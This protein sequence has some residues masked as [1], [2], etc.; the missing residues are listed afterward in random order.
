MAEAKPAVQSASG[1]S[2]L[3][4]AELV[5]ALSLAVDLGLGQPM[6]HLARSCLVACRLGQRMGLDDEERAGLY[7]VAML[8]WVG[9]IADS[10][11]AA[12]WFG[13][14]ISYRAEVYDIDMKPLPF[15]GY[16][17][18]RAGSGQ[19]PT[20]RVLVGANLV[21]TGA[22][23][24]QDSLRAHCQ[25]TGRIAERLGLGPDV[26]DPLQQIF[27]RW[28]AKGLPAGLGGERVAIAVRMW[29]IADVAEV[30]HR[31]GGVEAAVE[32]ARRRSGSQFDPAV[33]DE[34]IACAGEILDALPEGSCWD[35]LI[36][37]EPA[38]RPVLSER[39]F[40]AVLE[41]FAD[42]AD[43][44]SPYLRG[45]SRGVAD[46]AA[47]AAR[48]LGL[49]ANEI[50]AV[51]RAGLVHD[52]GRTGVPNSIWDKP[53][54]LS[55]VE[56]ERVRLHSYYTE[57]MLARPPALAALGAI[58]GLAHERLDGSGYHR[59]LSAASIPMPARVLAAADTYHAMVEPRPYRQT[60]TGDTAAR[61]LHEE[62]RA[63]RLD[64]NAVDAVLRSVGHK[65]SRP[66]A[67]PAGLTP[68]EV[69]VLAL[70]ARGASN[71]QIARGLGITP[72]TVG[73]HV[74]HIYTKAG[75]TTRAAAAMFALQNGLLRSVE[76]IG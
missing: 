32:V 49:P 41:V 23:S 4:L 52:I 64:G 46:L 36:D 33:V 58:A 53:G 61:N 10:H 54:P 5:G 63:G 9:C 31:R 70:L 55:T 69:E 27:S 48:R 42:Y 38:L 39:Q 8:G 73:N 14:D 19:S 15:F 20:R 47:A 50:L 60:L 44:K 24:V 74:E 21:A 35:D 2:G 43:L 68:R 51:R 7:Y 25:V 56:Q 22:R 75:V 66:P 45:H 29:Q 71:R 65:P 37:A 11:E 3:R 16:L 28:D 34:F 62:V 12:A 17:M 26:C 1:P 6:E 18:R 59:G 72:K 76:P 30:Y 13:D 57:R 67:G 40:D